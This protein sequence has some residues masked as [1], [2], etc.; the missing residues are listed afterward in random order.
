MKTTRKPRKTLS[1]A[2]YLQSIGATHFCPICH[3]Y[4]FPG[5]VFH[6]KTA[7]FNPTTARLEGG[8]EAAS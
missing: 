3:G 2:Q 8:L 6:V 7:P 4:F 1:F 5:H